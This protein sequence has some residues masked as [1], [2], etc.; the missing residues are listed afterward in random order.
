MS[1]V[2]LPKYD[3][4]EE[5][6]DSI[7]IEYADKSN[8]ADD[9]DDNT[10][11][12]LINRVISGIDED[13]ISQREWISRA[14]DLNRLV[15][16][17][18]E[19]KN[20]PLPQSANIKI[21][22]ITDACYQF[23]ARTY[24][25]I[26]QDGKVVKA[27]I[28]GE[29]LTG[30]LGRAAQAIVTHMNYQLLGPD[31]EWEASVDK[32]LVVLSNL[33]FVLKK[34]YFDPEQK[35]N[36]SDLCNYKDI[37]LRN[38]PEIQSLSDLR[39]ITHILHWHP[40]D[41]VTAGRSGVFSE[42]VVTEILA[43]YNPMNQYQECD[44]YESHCYFDLD[45]DGYEEPYIVTIHKSTRK[46]CRV[47]ARYDADNIKFND[48][49]KVQCILPTQYFTDYHFLPSPDGCFMSCGFGTLLQH[50]Q[51]MVN[52]ICNE[53]IDAGA[54]A[55]M[56]TG[57]IDSRIKVMGGQMM[58]DPGQ[59]MKVKGVMGKE[60]KD[61]IVPINY[62]EPS[63]VLYQLLGLLMNMAKELT[64]STDAMQGMGSG[65]NVPATTQLSMIEQGMKRF[66]AIQKR[67]YRS[68]KDEFHK[69]FNLN[70]KY[71]DP[72]EFIAICGVQGITAD[73]YTHP[74]LRI[75]PVADPNLSSDAQRLTQAQVI[76]QLA[77]QPTFLGSQYEA[78]RRLLEAAKVVNIAALLPPEA[79]KAPPKPDPKMIAAQQKGQIDQGKLQ[80][81]TRHQMMKEQESQAK[82]AKINAEIQQMQA[83]AAKLIAEASTTR[84]QTKLKELGLQLDTIKT[85]MSA[86]MDANKQ[87]SETA[88]SNNELK[89]KQQTIDNQHKQAMMDDHQNY[90]QLAIQKQ[91]QDQSY[92]VDHRD[93]DIQEDNNDQEVPSD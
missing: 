92:D 70:A 3:E 25:E 58:G 13:L 67:L 51:E 81:A 85:R 78:Q 8:I 9:L 77:S 20:T 23:A 26:V 62:K 40:N 12:T 54:L 84:D 41:L 87:M 60:L 28:V 79:A 88:R 18:K 61:G 89:L 56:Q 76:M 66:S 38:A 2:L 36:V 1:D 35:K 15:L 68:L 19:P 69:I 21:P 27:M 32:L 55:N 91:A 72:Q 11:Q 46:L 34:T 83:N 29:D 5:Q 30:F 7:L 49:G 90:T 64:S 17:T 53:L 86:A 24:P 63:T 50:L 52:T 31:S 43:S 48:D 10:K 33:G 44:L 59:W 4:N 6:P 75:I 74:S 39:R 47:K 82:S 42:E 80:I 71:V 65:T 37:I 22:L 14:D 93:L 57:F 73:V 16:L 45:D